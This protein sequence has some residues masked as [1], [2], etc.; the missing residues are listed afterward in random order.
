VLL[1]IAAAVLH[2]ILRPLVLAMALGV[3]GAVLIGVGVALVLVLA[4]APVWQLANGRSD[5]RRSHAALM[6][7]LWPAVAIVL[8]LAGAFVMWL[9]RVTPGEVTVFQ[10][11]QPGHGPLMLMSGRAH[12]RGDYHPT[13]LIDRAAGNVSRLTAVADWG[14][15]VSEDGKVAVWL[16]PD[17][18]FVPSSFELVSTKGA[19]G[20][21]ITP[22]FSY[23]LSADGSRV[24]TLNGKLVT[25]YDLANGRLLGSGA[26]LDGRSRHQMFFVSADVV[27]IIEHRPSRDVASPL[28]IFE[29]DVRSRSMQ[30]TGERMI[31]SSR[32]S[33][34]VSRA[35][36]SRMLVPTANAILD[37]R[38]GATVAAIEGDVANA[39]MLDDGRI[40]AIVRAGE[41]RQLQV[42]DRN[43]VLQYSVLLPDV[44]LARIV[45]E[46]DNGRLLI[47]GRSGVRAGEAVTP[48]HGQ[49]MLIVDLSKGTVERKID[50][51]RGP[52]P[53]WTPDP[54]LMRYASAQDFA[55]LD[56]EGKL[57][58]WSLARPEPRRLLR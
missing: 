47:L 30:K 50:G 38:T 26:G 55:A 35:D 31:A 42:H 44:G 28:R 46:T 43:G 13:F 41:A 21:P 48:M 33:M 8:F 58:A 24:A 40:A 45:G 39:A 20:I 18:L 36:A 3:A 32:M 34:S 54:R 5:I 15:Q 9:L 7:F 6:R 25:V 57:V 1:V 4:V 19:T 37:G 51:V 29:L 23:V 56:R 52:L 16:Q 14:S 27:R 12:N 17:G 53:R 49:A 11:D 2:L 10:I 22:A